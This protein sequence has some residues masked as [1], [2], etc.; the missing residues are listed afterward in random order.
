MILVTGGAGYIGSHI[1]VELLGA[2]FPVVV[3]D[4]LR[5]SRIEALQRVETIAGR[6]LD[7]IQADLRDRGALRALFAS[8]R[9]EAVIHLAGLKSVAESAADP[10]GYYACNV[11]GAIEL[12]GAMQEAG[13][14]R[15]VFSSSAT[16]YG[17]PQALPLTEQHPLAPVSA[18]G[19]TKLMIEQMLD[20]L[21]ASDPLWQVA[22]LR[23]FN[24]VG[25]HQSGLIGEHPNGPPNN[26]MPFLA[27]FVAGLRS[28]VT[29]FGD[30]YPTPDGTGVRDYVHVVDIAQAHVR[31]LQ[32]LPEGGFTLNLGTGRGYSVLEI[33]RAFEAASGTPIPYE[34]GPARSGDV[35]SCYADP[36]AADRLLGWRASRDLAAMCED[37]WR[38][39]RLNP[40]GYGA[41]EPA[42]QPGR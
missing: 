34:I 19:R 20:D 2:G 35:A 30:T 16:V 18:Y 42:L 3:V 38:W 40:T 32:R 17:V 23:Y 7:F 5:N 9:I 39:Q 31:A 27:Q 29:V 28:R 21:A 8:R 33:I 37:H 14:R 12:L 6:S 11:G 26:L 25:A 4:D 1:C 24:P 22:I 10:L 13:V 15:F 36:A 41:D